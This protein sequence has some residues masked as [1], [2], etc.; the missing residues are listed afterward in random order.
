M[1]AIQETSSYQTPKMPV[2]MDFQ[3]TRTT[4]NK[5]LLFINY[6][7]YAISLQQPNGLRQL[8]NSDWELIIGEGSAVLGI[9]WEAKHE[10]PCP[11]RAKRLEGMHTLNSPTNKNRVM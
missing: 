3:A 7:V 9:P 2:I 4:N 6:P 1:M 5:C 8:P 11:Q 10:N